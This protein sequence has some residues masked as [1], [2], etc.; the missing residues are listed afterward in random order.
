MSVDKSLRLRNTLVRHRS[1]LTRAQ[2]IQELIRQGL[3]EEGKDEPLGLPKVRV[4]RAK[5]R[6]KKKEEKKAEELGSAPV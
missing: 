1:V 2:R 6:G 4:L 3:F 5:K